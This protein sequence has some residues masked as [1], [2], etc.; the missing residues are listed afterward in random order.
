M[1]ITLDHPFV[2]ITGVDASIVTAEDW[3]DAFLGHV[4]AIK[5]NISLFSVAFRFPT[6][7]KDRAV[8][9]EK[10]FR[11]LWIV[12]RGQFLSP[13]YFPQDPEQVVNVSLAPGT[14]WETVSPLRRY[15]NVRLKVVFDPEFLVLLWSKQLENFDPNRRALLP[16]YPKDYYNRLFRPE[17]IRDVVHQL[18]F[19]WSLEGTNPQ[20][21]SDASPALFALVDDRFGYLLL[22]TVYD[23]LVHKPTRA[24]KLEA[25]EQFR[26]HHPH[27]M[28]WKTS[29]KFTGMKETEVRPECLLT[30]FFLSRFFY[31]PDTKT[32]KKLGAD[33]TMIRILDKMKDDFKQKH[34]PFYLATLDL[35]PTT[36]KPVYVP[37]QS[38]YFDH[39]SVKTYLG[40]KRKPQYF[41]QLETMMTLL[42]CRRMD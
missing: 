36:M 15:I 34:S 29:F 17:E 6:L 28:A 41:I 1:N 4:D 27:T 26:R 20:K 18:R 32:L 3:I 5:N 38:F 16:S 24:Q 2:T 42:R 8:L 25:L 37:Q 33:D 13:E 11:C 31:I 30:E 19:R 35:D 21:V 39:Q 10:V 23:L 7:S 22:E 40:R 9:G 14:T 12:L